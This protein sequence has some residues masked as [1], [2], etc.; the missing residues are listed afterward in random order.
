MDINNVNSY[1]YFLAAAV[2]VWVAL[3]N[4][5]DGNRVMALLNVASVAMFAFGGMWTLLHA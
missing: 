2:C 3:F 4:I 1:G 5:R